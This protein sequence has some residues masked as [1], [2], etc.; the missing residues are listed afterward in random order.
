MPRNAL[1]FNLTRDEIAK[2][3][4]EL[5]DINSNNEYVKRCLIILMTEHGVHLKVIANLLK[6]SKTT[7]N[8]WRQAFLSD[9]WEALKVKKVG[10][11]QKK[12]EQTTRKYCK[13]K[14]TSSPLKTV[15]NVKN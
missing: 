10:R 11:P 15:H 6:I 3:Y 14:I 4:Y 9:R 7:A 13:T 5:N 8:K 12:L 2:I 1:Q